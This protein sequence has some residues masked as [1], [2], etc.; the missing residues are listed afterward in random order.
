MA[1]TARLSRKH[2][3][4]ITAQPLFFVATADT[5]GHVNLSPKGMDTL[6]VVSDSAIR[7]LNLS[8]SGNETAAHVAATGRMTLLFCAFTGCAHI[9]RVYGQARVL[10]PRDAAWTAALAAFPS[11]AGKCSTSPSSGSRPRVAPVC[12]RWHSS[13][14]VAKPNSSRSTRTWG[15][16]ASRPFGGER[17]ASRWTANRPASIP[18][19]PERRCPQT[20]RPLT[21]DGP[22]PCAGYDD[23]SHRHAPR[24]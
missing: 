22:Q 9:L 7:W 1:A 16:R 12:R 14:A 8:G 23:A 6:R 17:T 15:P 2:R 10:H 11:I 18:T 3:D 5:G 24:S 4:F 21:H 13:A 19:G 20:G